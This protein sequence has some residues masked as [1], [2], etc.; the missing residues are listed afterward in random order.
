MAQS[1]KYDAGSYCNIV[2]GRKIFFFLNIELRAEH[3]LGHYI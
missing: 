1:T 3:Q 2:K